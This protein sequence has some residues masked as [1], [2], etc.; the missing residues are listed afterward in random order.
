MPQ[1]RIVRITKNYYLIH[2]NKVIKKEYSSTLFFGP[3]II[4]F[5]DAIILTRTTFALSKI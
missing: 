1:I 5:M 4:V 2:C 3:C